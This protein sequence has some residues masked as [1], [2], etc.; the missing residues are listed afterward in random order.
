MSSRQKETDFD[1]ASDISS[2]LAQ[3]S[4]DSRV[5]SNVQQII[6]RFQTV[7]STAKD[8]VKKCQEAVEDHKNFLEKYKQCADLLAAATSRY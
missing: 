7:Q 5:S 1:K 3:S 2:E 4:G 8:I 6:S